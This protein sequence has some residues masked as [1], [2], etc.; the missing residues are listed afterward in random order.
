MSPAVLK[1]REDLAALIALWVAIHGGDPLPSKVVVDGTALLIA[2]ALDNHLAH[3]IEG[4]E[5]E[6]RG[7]AR[8][9]E[10]LKALDI[11]RVDD[12]GGHGEEFFCFCFRLSRFGVI[13][14]ICFRVEEVER[15]LA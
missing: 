10:R 15:E 6:G 9:T 13:I 5:E 14:C 3:T 8:L 7:K 2:A 12:E 4:V 11:E 1:E